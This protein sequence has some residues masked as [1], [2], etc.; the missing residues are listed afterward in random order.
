MT[1]NSNPDRRNAEILFANDRFYAAFA[2]GDAAEMAALWGRDG[3]VCCLHPGWE[4]LHQRDHI[5]GSWNAILRE[6]PPIRCLAPSVVMLGETGAAVICWE[7][8]GDTALIATN[9]YRLEAGEWRLVHHQAG[10]VAG[11]PPVP[12]TSDRTPG[13]VN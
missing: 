3:A 9:L 8:V 6:P 10:P 13:A 1:D 5:I 7:Q 4:P 12:E 2:Q 11:D